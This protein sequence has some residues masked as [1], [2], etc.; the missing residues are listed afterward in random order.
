MDKPVCIPDTITNTILWNDLL[1]KVSDDFVL[2]NFIRSIMEDQESILHLDCY[3]QEDIE[4]A[5]DDGVLEAKIEMSESV[6]TD[7]SNALDDFENALIDK[8]PKLTEQDQLIITE[9]LEEV[10]TRVEDSIDDS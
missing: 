9:L 8:I 1:K 4:Q 2:E 7:L 5:E 3:T 6:K 10:Q